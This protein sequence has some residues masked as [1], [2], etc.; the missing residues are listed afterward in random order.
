V[1]RFSGAIQPQTRVLEWVETQRFGD[2]IDNLYGC[3]PYS[4]RRNRTRH[5]PALVLVSSERPV[6]V[7]NGQTYLDHEKG[8]VQE[9]V[10]HPTR[11]EVTRTHCEGCK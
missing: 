8:N 1:D 2:G 6:D 9:N 10:L 7:D 11:G 3:P 4:D 5:C